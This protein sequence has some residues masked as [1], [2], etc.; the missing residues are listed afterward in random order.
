MKINQKKI[1]HHLKLATL[2][3]ICIPVLGLAIR[4]LYNAYLINEAKAENINQPQHCVGLTPFRVE[5]PPLPKDVNFICDVTIH[6][7]G[8][9][10][11]GLQ[12]PYANSEE[13]LKITAMLGGPI[14]YRKVG[15]KIV[16]VINDSPG[17]ISYSIYKD[18]EKIIGKDKIFPK[19]T[20]R[21]FSKTGGVE[22]QLTLMNMSK[23]QKYTIHVSG[24][25]DHYRAYQGVYLIVKRRIFN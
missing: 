10:Q 9:Y 17:E 2:T 14:T 25:P 5:I 4:A 16:D 22:T 24:I 11:V 7:D 21:S 15:D 18:G 3:L 12:Y 8:P 19:V 23:G 6:R 13:A 20:S 1:A